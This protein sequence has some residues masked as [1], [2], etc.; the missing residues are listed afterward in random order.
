MMTSLQVF[1][2][3]SARRWMLGY[4]SWP[5]AVLLL[6]PLVLRLLLLPLQL[7]LL[8]MQLPL[9]LLLLQLPAQSKEEAS[10]EPHRSHTPYGI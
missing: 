3:P 10:H 6:I 5:V 4:V 7:I 9:L 1:I 8:V 2:S